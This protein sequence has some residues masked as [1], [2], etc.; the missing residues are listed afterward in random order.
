MRR[1]NKKAVSEKAPE[2]KVKVEEKPIAEKSTKKSKSD[3]K[4][5]K[6]KVK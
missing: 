1:F 2:K 4:P 6:K 3:P 5:K